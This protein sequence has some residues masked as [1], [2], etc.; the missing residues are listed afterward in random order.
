[1]SRLEI[2]PFILE[3]LVFGTPTA[4][5][6][7]AL[8]VEHAKAYCIKVPQYQHCPLADICQKRLVIKPTTE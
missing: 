8:L 4:G 1:M 5:T 6:C 2:I 3:S 7:D